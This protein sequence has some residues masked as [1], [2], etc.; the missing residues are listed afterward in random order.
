MNI[1]KIIGIAHRIKITKPGQRGPLFRELETEI[2]AADDAAPGYLTDKDRP[3]PV[4]R[5]ALVE[6]LRDMLNDDAARES[7]RATAGVA[8]WLRDLRA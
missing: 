3:Q 5:L 8:R 4:N 2:D 1:G 7:P 6:S